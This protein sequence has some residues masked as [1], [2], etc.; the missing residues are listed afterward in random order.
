MANIYDSNISTIPGAITDLVKIQ[1]FD[2][3]DYDTEFQTIR[4]LYPKG[5]QYFSKTESNIDD[6]NMFICLVD[7]LS[8]SDGSCRVN[9]VNL[10][11][12]TAANETVAIIL[13][14]IGSPIITATKT[15]DAYAV[16]LDRG[17]SMLYN[18]NSVIE[19]GKI[20][21]SHRSFHIK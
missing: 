7:D 13:K 9:L 15:D 11:V 21:S 6:Q 1:V 4:L 20:V 8:T 12:D 17:F 5:F 19:I 16:H 18:R 3:A 10:Y 2:S 14:K